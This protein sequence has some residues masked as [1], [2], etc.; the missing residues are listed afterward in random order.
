MS[1]CPICECESMNY[2]KEGNA[3]CSYCGAIPSALIKD[4]EEFKRKF[5]LK[6]KTDE[7]C[8]FC[9]LESE[10]HDRKKE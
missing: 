10:K 7:P 2:D 9:Y 3:I 5:C 1:M 4:E 6:H 8:Q